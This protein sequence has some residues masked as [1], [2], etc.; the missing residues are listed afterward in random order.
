MFILCEFEEQNVLVK[1]NNFN[2][3]TQEGCEFKTKIL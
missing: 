2:L 1:H 3:V